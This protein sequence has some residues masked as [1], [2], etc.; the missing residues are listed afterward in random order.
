M[1]VDTSA[2]IAVMQQESETD[3]LIHLMVEAPALG[4]GAPSLVEIALVLGSRLQRDAQDIVS[5]FIQEFDIEPIPFG[6]LH[7]KVASAAFAKFGKGRHPAK[8]NFG[9]CMSYAVARIAD[10][11]LLFVGEDF[12]KTDIETA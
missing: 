4:I 7:W 3:R 11:P 1:I 6:P 12:A 9:D 8:L 10:K 2:A 5:R